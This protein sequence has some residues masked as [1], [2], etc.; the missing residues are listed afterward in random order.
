MGMGYRGS[1]VVVLILLFV[2]SSIY[3]VRLGVDRVTPALIAHLTPHCISPRVGL[4]T[5][6]TGISTCGKRTVDILKSRGFNIVKLFAPEHGFAGVIRAGDGCANT[7]DGVTGIPVI[8][9][10]RSGGNAVVGGKSINPEDLLD[11]DLLLFDIQDSGM[12]H[13]TYISTLYCV[14]DA[15]GKYNLPVVILDRPNPLGAVMEGPLVDDHLR[16]FIG[17]APIPVRHGMTVG[18][19]ARYFVRYSLLCKPKIFVVVMKEYFRDQGLTHFLAPLSP[20]IQAHDA[21]KGYSFLGLLGEIGPFDVGV[22]TPHAFSVIALVHDSPYNKPIFWKKLIIILKKHTISARPIVYM[23]DK[24]KYTGISLSIADVNKVS[25]IRVLHDLLNFFKK[26][27][28]TFLYRKGFDKAIGISEFRDY[29]EGSIE[30]KILLKKINTALYVF[31][32][33]A[34]KVCIYRPLPQL[35]FL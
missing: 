3:S 19:L 21:V 10:Y 32:E 16:S 33:K 23:R 22:G 4:I 28:I 25:T 20:N 12:R 35:I 18:E 24:N 31:F 9:L 6:Q 17:I 5:N 2:S 30:H 26:A 7:K 8:S 11:V 29:Y 13:Y 34:R 27:G 14:L 1:T 15:A